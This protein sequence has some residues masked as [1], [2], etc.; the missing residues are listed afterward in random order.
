MYSI[1]KVLHQK[2]IP[3][4]NIAKGTTDPAVKLTALTKSKIQKNLAAYPQATQPWGGGRG[5]ACIPGQYHCT[6]LKVLY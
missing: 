6:D 4:K 2:C 3:S 5:G 1:E